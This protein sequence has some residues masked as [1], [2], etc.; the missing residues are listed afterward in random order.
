[1]RR[2]RGREKHH[3][4]QTRNSKSSGH[5]IMSDVKQKRRERDLPEKEEKNPFL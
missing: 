4:L 3:K 2:S 5:I 1:M